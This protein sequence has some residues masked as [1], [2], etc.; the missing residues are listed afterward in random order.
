MKNFFDYYNLFAQKSLTFDDAVEIVE[1]LESADKMALIIEL[2]KQK[3]S[4]PKELEKKSLEHLRKNYILGKGLDNVINSFSMILGN[5]EYMQ[6]HKMD[7]PATRAI[8]S[9]RR[10]RAKDNISEMYLLKTYEE[11][12]AYR[13]SLKANEL[14]ELNMF[15]PELYDSIEENMG[16]VDKNSY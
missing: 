12:K 10:S 7:F 4:T 3:I 6:S 8:N 5:E 1:F 15:G 16:L 14:A 9:L 13:E 2:A 11:K